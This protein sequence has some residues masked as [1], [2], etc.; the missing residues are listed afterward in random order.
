LAVG[1]V[2]LTGFTAFLQTLCNDIF[3]KSRGVVKGVTIIKGVLIEEPYVIT[4]S[5]KAEAFSPLKRF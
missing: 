5:F 1:F 2:G 4:F 3:A